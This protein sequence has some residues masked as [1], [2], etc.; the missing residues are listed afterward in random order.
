MHKCL[1]VQC[2]DVQVCRCTNVWVYKYNG[3]Q[4]IGVQKYGCIHV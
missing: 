3:V 1:G 4:Y 2:M